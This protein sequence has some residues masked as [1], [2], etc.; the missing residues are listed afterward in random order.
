MKRDPYF[1]G[2]LLA[3]T[4]LLLMIVSL[5]YESWKSRKIQRMAQTHSLQKKEVVTEVRDF[6]LLKTMTGGDGSP[7]VIVPEGTFVMGSLPTEG[8][9]D[10][11]PQRTVYLSTYAIDLYEVTHTRFASYVKATRTAPPVI[12]FFP[13]DLSRITSPDQPVVG[14]TWE[15]AEGYCRWLGKRLPTEAEW[16]KAARGERGLKWPWG[17]VFGEGLANVQGEEDG[18]RYSSPPGKFERG[19]SPLGLYDMAGNVSEWVGDWYDPRYYLQG[20]FRD[21]KGPNQGKY[22]VYKG[23]AWEDAAAN[24]RSAKRYAAA[25]HQAGAV[26][27]FRCASDL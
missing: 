23:G 24:V 14:V 1:Y 5:G 17:N 13:E 10:E 2:I 9:D 21:P 26:I 15:Q 11:I 8:D 4:A 7:M 20:P 19:R 18:Y 16:E 27:G 25:P 12:P 6:S 22:R 3:F